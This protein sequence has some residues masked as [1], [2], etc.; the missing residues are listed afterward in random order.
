MPL[1]QR[2]SSFRFED[3]L[4]EEDYDA[5]APPV[6]AAAAAPVPPAPAAPELPGLPVAG[7]AAE[8]GLL[9]QDTEVIS[10]AS[11]PAGSG[12]EP[13]SPAERPAAHRSPRRRAALPLLALLLLLLAAAA[14]GG[15]LGGHGSPSAPRALAHPPAHVRSHSGARRKL[16]RRRRAGHARHA[17]RHPHSR[18]RARHVSVPAVAP[19]PAAS[20][21]PLPAP[22][23]VPAPAPSGSASGG[24]FVIGG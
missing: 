6:A 9:E 16:S 11:A 22:R 1:F 21:A 3:E 10:E 20:P 23:L 24:E 15:R 13:A 5:T 19:V 4:L 7:A 18:A 2:A 17:R 8:P 12:S 14:F